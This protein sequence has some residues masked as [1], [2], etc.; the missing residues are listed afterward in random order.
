MHTASVTRFTAGPC[1]PAA[2]RITCNTLPTTCPSLQRLC[3]DLYRTT[4]Q[5]LRPAPGTPAAAPKTH[6]TINK[7]SHPSHST[8]HVLHAEQPQ[9]QQ[10]QGRERER[11]GARATRLEGGLLG[12]LVQGQVILQRVG[13]QGDHGGREGLAVVRDE[14][15]VARLV[16]NGVHLGGHHVQVDVLE[17]AHNVHQ[18]AG[19]VGGH[20]LQQGGRAVGRLRYVNARLHHRAARAQG[21]VLAVGRLGGKA[22]RLGEGLDQAVEHSH[23]DL[24]KA[25]RLDN[26]LAG[27]C[28]GDE[29]GATAT[30]LPSKLGTANVEVQVLQS[31]DGLEQFPSAVP[32]LDRHN[33]CEGI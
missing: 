1:S 28:L 9:L 10:H 21:L 2:H 24:L 19:A 29:E 3:P 8:P 23:A 11:K 13:D 14:E 15:L 7:W 6:D 27:I 33:S 12:H 20:D 31:S 30:S 17:H 32:I 22:G 18:Q 5:P 16:A 25:G 4:H 26:L